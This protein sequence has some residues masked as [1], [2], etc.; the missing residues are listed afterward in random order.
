MRSLLRIFRQL[1]ISHSIRTSA[2]RS[3]HVCLVAVGEHLESELDDHDC[4]FLQM[5]FAVPLK[6]L[7]P[8]EALYKITSQIRIFPNLQAS[9]VNKSIS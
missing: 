9:S 6:D 4:C 3:P 5:T 2:L 1:R 8:A 7:V